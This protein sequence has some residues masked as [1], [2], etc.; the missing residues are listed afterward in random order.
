MAPGGGIYCMPFDSLRSLRAFDSLCTVKD[1]ER[2]ASIEL[3][4]YE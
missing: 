1:H 2:G 3:A 4:R